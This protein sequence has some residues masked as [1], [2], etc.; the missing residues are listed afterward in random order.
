[1][2]VGKGL[3]DGVFGPMGWLALAI[4]GLFTLGYFYFQLQPAKRAA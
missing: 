1:M 3:A 2:I 4:Y